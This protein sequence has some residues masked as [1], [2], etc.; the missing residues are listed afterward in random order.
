MSTRAATVTMLS[1]LLLAF[2]VALVLY[3]QMPDPMPS[4]WNAAGEVDGYMPKFWGL[5]LL[6]LIAVG[7]FWLVP[8][9]PQ[10]RPAQGQH[11][12]V[13]RR[14]QRHDGAADRLHAVRLCAD[15]AVGARLPVQYDGDAASRHGGAVHRHR[16]PDRQGQTQLLCGHPHAL[17][18]EQRHGLGQDA[19]LGKWTFIGAGGVSIVCAFLGEIGFWVFTFS[20]L[21]AAFVPVVYSYCCGSVRHLP[22]EP[23]R[24]SMGWRWA[25]KRAATTPNGASGF[26]ASCWD[27]AAAARWKRWRGSPIAGSAALRAW[28]GEPP[29]ARL[30]VRGP[31]A[32]YRCATL[33]H[34]GDEGATTWPD[35]AGW[36]RDC[37]RWQATGGAAVP[38]RAGDGRQRAGAGQMPGQ[39]FVSRETSGGSGLGPT[40]GAGGVS[41]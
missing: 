41:E 23:V 32:L 26:G 28:L 15:L 4:H 21:A 36:P 25:R 18:V 16:L 2:L 13:Q 7:I 12:P 20:M 11:R 10:D 14:L 34:E 17:D 38:G 5:F 1:M 6:P 27:E 19:Q 40:Q 3:P 33:A 35:G 9:N 29:P 30:G 24:T 37:G 8:G 31:R 39:G 22:S